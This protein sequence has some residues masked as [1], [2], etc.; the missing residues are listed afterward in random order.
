MLALA[1]ASLALSIP[2]LG[3]RAGTP[4]PILEASPRWVE[5]YW[6][7]W[8]NVQVATVKSDG[9][10]GMQGPGSKPFPHGVIAEG[11]AENYDGSLAVALFGRWA[12]RACGADA[13]IRWALG[14]VDTSG[15]VSN[16]AGSFAWEAHGPPIAGLVA[17]RLYQ[18]TGDKAKLE[19]LLAP[20]VRRHAYITARYTAE[21]EPKPDNPK[22]KPKVRHFVAPGLSVIPGPAPEV[23]QSAEAVGLLLQGAV[24]LRKVARTL[25]VGRA[26]RVYEG[27]VER[28]S[29]DLAA[30]WDT[31]LKMLTGRNA[32][33]EPSERRSL[34]PLWGLIGG[35]VPVSVSQ[36]A[37]GALRDPKLFYRRTLFPLLP[38]TDPVYDG[39]AGVRPLYSYLTLRSLIDCGLSEQAGRAAESML[40]V[41]E[42]A[43]GSSLTLFDMYGP[44]TRTPAPRANP[45]SLEAGLIVIAALI[46][47]VI[48]IDVDASKSEVQWNIRRADRHGIANLR[49][50]NNL[51][52]LRCGPRQT[53]GDLPTVSIDCERPFTLSIAWGSQKAKKRFP[54]GRHQWTP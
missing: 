41:Y 28:G 16:A 35:E 10:P 4:E 31:D 2:Q 23:E 46:E 43:A 14:K 20:L 38:K 17:W 3:W 39:S 8:E 52:T 42:G 53:S 9:P 27:L 19:P 48:G 7:A 45:H 1:A 32:E 36:A 51:V 40:S 29:A 12:F 26:E 50:G 33:D 44:E 15:R 37:L 11:G 47:A 25:G 6:K 21:P 30:M 49:F 24:F 5:L 34:V 54:E 22:D 13:T 18:I